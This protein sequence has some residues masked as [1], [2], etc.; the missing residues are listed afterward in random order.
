MDLNAKTIGF[1]L[2]NG[3]VPKLRV[4]VAQLSLR[5]YLHLIIVHH[6]YATWQKHWAIS[7][8]N[9]RLVSV[10]QYGPMILLVKNML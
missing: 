6:S 3:K 8:D 4:D 10:D 9:H 1:P 2:S 7:L 5:S